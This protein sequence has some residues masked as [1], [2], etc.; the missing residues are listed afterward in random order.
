MSSQLNTYFTDENG[1]TSSFYE[2][3]DLKSME[4]QKNSVALLVEKGYQQNLISKSDK[5]IMQPSG[6]PNRLYGLPKVHKGIKEGSNIPPCRCRPIVS[7]SG[8]NT[9]TISALVDHY[10]KHLV[11]DLSSYV[12]DTPD[13]LRIIESENEKGPQHKNTFPVTID[14]TSLY[15]S[16]PANGESGGIQAFQTFLDKRSQ[17]EKD[18]MPTKFLMECL[19][20]VL[21]GNIFTFNEELFIQKIGTAMGT[22]LAPTYACLFMG[23]LEEEFLQRKWSG[24]Q[25][26]MWKR[27]IDDIFF[28]WTG[29]VQDLESFI[30]ELNDHH[31]H[32]KF[33]A[34][35][36][37]E[38]KEVPFLD[39][40][41]SIDEDGFIQTDLYTKETAKVSYLL[42]NSS[43]PGHITKNIPYSLGYRLLRICSVPI[44][45]LKRLEELKQDLISRNYHPKII[46]EAFEKI[47]K[48]DRKKALEKVEKVKDQKTPFVTKFHPSLPSISKI[49]RKHWQVMVDDDPRLERIFPTPSVV[50]YKRGKN[51]RD[52]LVRAK[53]CTLRKS[54][55][56]KPGY[57][58]C[59]RGFFNQCLTCALIPKNGIKTHQCNKTKKTFKIDSPV[60][61][62]T[63]NVIYRITCKKP[64][65]KNFVYIGQT[66]RKFCDR[67]SEH[68]GYVSQK[69]FDQVCGEHFNKPGH[70]QLDMLPVILEE[71]T[72]KDDDFLRLRREELW[73]RRYQS[74]EFG[75]NKHS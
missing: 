58:S 40:K 22:K 20:L 1:T 39:M 11:K 29:S 4:E 7:N 75:A 65:C 6:K 61:C 69:K 8:S 34:N 51:L 70:S 18:T 57:S 15:T 36:D 54:N 37:I 62:V 19:E 35:Y 27:Y 73:I 74:I 38:T 3:T 33:T 17:E 16:I 32:I 55:R 23:W 56:K 21:N 71:V 5:N 12:Q 26:K 25:P 28:L 46:N 2:K 41:V 63:T 9:E 59:D 24:V 53:V 68:R 72:P 64:K 47:K 43:H 45:F 14:V 31:S 67:F 49:V 10:S 42:P 48:I 30:T 60:N 52:L 13:F 66:K 50:A 44:Q